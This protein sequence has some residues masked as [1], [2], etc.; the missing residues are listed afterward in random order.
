MN[1]GGKAPRAMADIRAYQR[2]HRDPTFSDSESNENER[3]ERDANEHQRQITST[4]PE[5]APAP[6]QNNAVTKR[7]LHLFADDSF[8]DGNASAVDSAM[9][10]PGKNPIDPSSVDYDCEEDEE[11]LV[12]KPKNNK[13]QVKQ[14]KSTQS[15]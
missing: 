2:A 15:Q 5:A 10:T 3:H 13:A 8:S 6:K 9:E 1:P 12:V 11:E 4:R 7:K 14:S